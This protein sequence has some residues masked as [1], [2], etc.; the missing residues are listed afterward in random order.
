MRSGAQQ[1]GH[2]SYLHAIPDFE[3]SITGDER[4]RR[5]TGG[6]KKGQEN[7]KSEKLRELP[8]WGAFEV[9]FCLKLSERQKE[10]S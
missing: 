3:T 1:K 7:Q 8:L 2:C 6:G 10:K 9:C 4:G 5:D